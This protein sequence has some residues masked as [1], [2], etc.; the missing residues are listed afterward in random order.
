MSVSPVHVAYMIDNETGD[1]LDE[2]HN[3]LNGRRN[4]FCQLLNV[5][6]V[7]NIRQTVIHRAEPLVLEFSIAIIIEKLKR[8]KL[9][10]IDRIPKV[11]TSPSRR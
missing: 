1:L 6:R 5:H 8:F 3:I 7:N 4:I 11:L 9:P 10:G 2:S